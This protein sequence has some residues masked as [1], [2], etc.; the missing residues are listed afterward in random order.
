MDHQ[1]ELDFQEIKKELEADVGCELDVQGIL[2]L[3]GVNE[4]GI[5]Y[6]D[7]SK[8]EK[9]DLMH[10]AICT[11]LE[12]HGFYEFIGRDEENWPHFELKKELPPL[13][14]MQQQHLLKDAIISYFRQNEYVSTDETTS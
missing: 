13:D 11:I 4:L 1:V 8:D 6:K 14:H 5:G 12:P 9:T 2:F 3:I 7:F 10:I